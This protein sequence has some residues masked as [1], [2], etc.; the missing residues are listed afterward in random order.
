MFIIIFTGIIYL[1][2][3][4]SSLL[5]GYSLTKKRKI[6]VIGAVI[7]YTLWVIYDIF[8]YSYSGAL[9]DGIVALSNMLILI[10]ESKFY[11]KYFKLSPKV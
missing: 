8:V 1:L 11:N 4:C 5:D 2:P 7:S 10:R 6:V 3:I 9:T